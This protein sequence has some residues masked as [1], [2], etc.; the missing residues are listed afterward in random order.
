MAEQGGRNDSGRP[1]SLRTRAI[2]WWIA[3]SLA[4]GILAALRS[5]VDS[6]LGFIV[7]TLAVGA[8]WGVPTM[9]LLLVLVTKLDRRT[10]EREGLPTKG[11]WD[12]VAVRQTIVVDAPLAVAFAR[13]VDAVGRV[14]KASVTNADAH[15]GFIKGRVRMTQRSWGERLTVRVRG[16]AQAQSEIEILS[17]PR[18]RTTIVDY[19]KNQR[20]VDAF[21]AAMQ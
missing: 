18:M 9:I 7:L 14:P 19:G 11:L 20:N 5:D 6:G 17:E 10:R 16:Y 12:P 2:A 21:V 13:A 15:A 1:G 8:A 3:C 4:F